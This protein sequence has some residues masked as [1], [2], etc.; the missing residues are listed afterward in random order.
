MVASSRRL[1]RKASRGLARWL[2]E[3][4][5]LWAGNE[6]QALGTAQSTYQVWA[7]RCLAL[8][9]CS[10]WHWAFCTRCAA[11]TEFCPWQAQ[12]RS[13]RAP[14]RLSP[15][16]NSHSLPVLGRKILFHPA[17]CFFD[18]F[19]RSRKLRVRG[20]P[21][22]PLLASC[23]GCF[24]IWDRG[25]ECSWNAWFGVL[26]RRSKWNTCR[27]LHC[28]RRAGSTYLCPWVRKRRGFAHYE[29]KF[30]PTSPHSCNLALCWGRILA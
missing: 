17:E 12:R 21:A 26:L 10:R 3:K 24:L 7:P 23:K 1:V 25:V 15:F 11:R 8:R 22:W 4:F 2:G 5:C 18:I 30:P 19:H 29:R 9:D 20:Q 16:H 6:W 13:S 27:N 14:R 28:R